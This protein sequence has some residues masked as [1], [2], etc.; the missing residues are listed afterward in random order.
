MF[1]LVGTCQQLADR[2]H[3]VAH[4]PMLSCFTGSSNAS[5]LRRHQ[6]RIA[7][8]SP[9]LIPAVVDEDE[10]H[11]V[12]QASH[13]LNT[14]PKAGPVELSAVRRCPVNKLATEQVDPLKQPVENHPPLALD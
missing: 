2:E 6:W 8:R 9:V 3:A 14:P 1:E 5:R 12:H 4:G 7:H 11:G 13:H 10:K